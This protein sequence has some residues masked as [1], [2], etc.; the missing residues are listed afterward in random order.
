MFTYLQVSQN[1]SLFIYEMASAMDLSQAVAAGVSSGLSGGRKRQRTGTSSRKTSSRKAARSISRSI[2]WKGQIVPPILKT[3][4]RYAENVAASS[5]GGEYT[6]VFRLNS[7]NDFDYSGGG[8]QPMGHDE[9]ATLYENYRVT[10]VRWVVKAFSTD[11]TD[12]RPMR[13]S[14]WVNDVTTSAATQNEGEEQPGAKNALALWGG[15]SEARLSGY[16]IIA[17][18]LSLTTDQA[19]SDDLT[20]ASF[21]SNPNQVVYLHVRFQTGIASFACNFSINAV[22]DV[23]CKN[24]KRLA[25]S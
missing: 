16:T 3:K 17:N 2:A 6:Y 10:G 9:L 15:R 8:H 21:G 12:A 20:Q 11:T 14:A 19:E 25:L 23:E 13:C 4:L 22:I 5:A 18:E 1:R 7:I 24:P